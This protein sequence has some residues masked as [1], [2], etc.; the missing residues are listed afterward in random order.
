[1]HEIPADR[2]ELQ[3]RGEYAEQITSL[4][5]ETNPEN[6][7]KIQASLVTHAIDFVR[8][9]ESWRDET[10]YYF[11]EKLREGTEPIKLKGISTEYAIEKTCK[12]LDKQVSPS[13]SMLYFGLGRQTYLDYMENL[14]I[15]AKN[16][17]KEEQLTIVC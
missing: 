14:A 5:K 2:W 15:K 13:L 17:L 16:R 8:K 3:S 6:L 10:R 4:I 1:V 12:W 11:W 9:G 7:A